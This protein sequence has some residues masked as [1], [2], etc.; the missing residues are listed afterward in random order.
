M[1]LS[2]IKQIV[3]ASSVLQLSYLT[4]ELP[5]PLTVS[6]CLCDGLTLPNLVGK[7]LLVVASA[8]QFPVE[9]RDEY[10]QDEDEEQGTHGGTK[11]HSHP[12]WGCKNTD[13]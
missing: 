13:E 1:F 9:D 12:V 8:A 6:C 2:L 10:Q 4:P 7:L 3:F 5:A 11:Y